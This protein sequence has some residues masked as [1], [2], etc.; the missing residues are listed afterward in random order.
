MYPPS[1]SLTNGSTPYEKFHNSIPDI[2][3]LR[4][5]GEYVYV[6]KPES[7]CNSKLDARATLYRFIGIDAGGKSWQ[8]WNPATRRAVSSRDCRFPADF[9]GAQSPQHN[10]GGELDFQHHTFHIENDD[11]DLEEIPESNSNIPNSSK[12]QDTN[13]TPTIPTPPIPTPS[14]PIHTPPNSTEPTRRSTRLAEKQAKLNAAAQPPEPDDDDASVLA[15]DII[16]EEPLTYLEAMA[17]S[18]A[19]K[20]LAAMKEEMNNLSKLGTFE[21][22]K[23]PTGRKAIGCKWVFKLK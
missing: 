21:I 12:P 8:C 9:G 3:L 4:I 16:D 6:H 2:S 18:N 14:T 23:L 20:W 10:A 5:W 1:S 19:D 11:L 15:Y 7:E 13:I 17:S 22:T